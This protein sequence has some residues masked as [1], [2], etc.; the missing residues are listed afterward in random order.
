MPTGAVATIRGS[1][2]EFFDLDAVELDDYVTGLDPGGSCRTLVV[3]AGDERAADLAEVEAFGDGIVDILDANAE[4][5]AP[6]LAIFLQLFDDRDDGRGRIGEADAAPTAG[7]RQDGC[8]DADDITVHV[9]QGAARIT[10]VDGSVDLKETVV[11]AGVDIAVAGRDDA[12]GHAAA[13][14]EGIA[15][16]HNPIADAHL[17][18]VAEFHGFQRFFRL[19]PQNRNVDLRIFADDFGLQLLPVGKDHGHFVGIGNH[20][21]IGDDNAGWIDDEAGPERI[22]LALVRTLRLI[23][24]SLPVAAKELFEHF[25]ERRTRLE[26]RHIGRPLFLEGLSRRNI[27]DR[28]AN[29]F[30]KISERIW[31]ARLSR[32]HHERHRAEAEEDR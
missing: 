9:E 26:L 31:A 4:P 30:G 20:V 29:G 8:I 10:F 19:H 24:F 27:D 7:G 22:G 32:Q 14:T 11:R 1:S 15:D 13:E 12:G 6:C 21:I 17:V 23:V 5:A 18:A 16:R 2:R 3:S 25:V 28:I